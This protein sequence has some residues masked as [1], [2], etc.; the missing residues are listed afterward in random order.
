M[1]AILCFAN[2]LP[3][4]FVYDSIEIVERNPMVHEPGRWLD[5][6]T[7][8]HW[9][10]EEGRT[11]N[12]DLLYRPVALFTYRLVRTL[13]GPSPWP[14]HLVNVLLH[15]AICVLVVRLIRRDGAS[16]A[17]ALVAGLAF[18]V[19]PIHTEVVNDV[20]GRTDLLATLGIL[21]A[22]VAHRRLITARAGATRTLPDTGKVSKGA[23]L[24][25][26]I[27]G[28]AAFGAMG[29]KES[30]VSILLL[31][32]LFD[33]FWHLQATQR[34]GRR[35]WWSWPTATRLA[36]LVIPAAVYF[37]LRYH[38]VGGRLFQQPA[39]TK[40]INVLVG[41]PLWQHILGVFQAWGMYWQKTIWPAVLCPDY[42]VNAVRLATD[43]L[44]FDV[45]FGVAVAAGLVIAAAAGGRRGAPARA[46]V[47]AAGIITY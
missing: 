8:D 30:G 10:Q 15:A 6:W 42:S 20:V 4:G 12:R 47:L 7:V 1:V 39:A 28:V 40:T 46:I 41:A 9:Y 5:L 37:A 17:A 18:A 2:S 19:L 35:S 16:P 13:A 3:N 34:R 45:L 38:A 29:S 33:A 32:P 21:V 44:D 14:Q 22:L 25:V 24:W 43:V 31:I 27:A 23:R 36:Y 11:A 26:L